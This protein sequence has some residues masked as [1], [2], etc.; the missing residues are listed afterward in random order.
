ML[1]KGP[2]M[3][4]SVLH[5]CSTHTTCT[6]GQRTGFARVLG[7]GGQLPGGARASQALVV[8]GAGAD[9]VPAGAAVHPEAALRLQRGQRHALG[10]QHAL[11]A[12]HL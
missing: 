9:A 7:Q 10:R 6:R 11:L 5:N 4:M 1:Q 8:G 3:Q 12:P 2:D